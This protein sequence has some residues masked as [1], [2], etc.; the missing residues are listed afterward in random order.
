MYKT[1]MHVM[2]VDTDGHDIQGPQLS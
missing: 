2:Y 1:K